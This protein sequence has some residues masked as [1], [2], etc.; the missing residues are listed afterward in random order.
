MRI[1]FRVKLRVNLRVKVND[2]H[3]SKFILN[4]A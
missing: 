2:D 1:K 3:T 4:D